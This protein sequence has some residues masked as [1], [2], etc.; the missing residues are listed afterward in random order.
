MDW[1]N[2]ILGGVPYLLQWLYR[3]IFIAIVA[4]LVWRYWERVVAAVR[5]FIESL[6]RLWE[7]LF[8]GRSDAAEEE[9]AVESLPRPKPFGE[10]ANPFTGG[11]GSRLAPAELVT[12]SFRALEAWGFERGCPRDQEQTPHEYAARLRGCA[13]PLGDEA[14]YLAGLYCRTAYSEQPVTPEHAQRLSRLWQ[15]METHRPPP[16]T[17]TPVGT[18]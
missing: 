1:V 9:S 7:S 13:A 11:S 3:L 10:F 6:R 17:S 12:Y 8:G 5:E 2:K 16:V 15:L 14:Q 18:L 4:Y